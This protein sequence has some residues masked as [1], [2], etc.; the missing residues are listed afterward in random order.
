ML[1]IC[2]MTG[3]IQENHRIYL[4]EIIQSPDGSEIRGNQ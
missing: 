4:P 3:Q 1:K 2:V